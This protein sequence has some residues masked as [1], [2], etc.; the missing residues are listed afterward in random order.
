MTGLE[1]PPGSER[2]AGLAVEL[3]EALAARVNHVPRTHHLRPDG[4]P[5]FV[6]R[7]IREASPYLIQHAHNPV[8]WR[9][10][11]EE[12]LAEAAALDRPVFLSVGYATCHWCHV[13][14]EESFD[15]LEVAAVLNASFVPVKLDREQRPDVDQAYILA[16]M[17]QHRHAGWPNSVWL[18]PDGRP[19]HT[20]TYFPKP[21]FVQVLGAIAQGW[22]G[23]QRDQFEG[24][25]GQ[26]ADAMRRIPA[27]SAPPAELTE[28]P[29]RA[30]ADL[31]RLFNAEHGGFSQGTQFP[32]EG[33]LL[34]LM[35]H[36]RRTGDAAARDAALT[37]LI[38]MAA[39][40][41]HDHVGGGF[42][43]Y[44]VDV[45]WRTPHFE[46]MLYNQALLMRC[47]TEAWQI[48]GRPDFAR[49]VARC[50]DYVLRDMTAPDGAFYSAED[51]DSLDVTGKQ[52]EG[53]FYVW[54]PEE[55]EDDWLRD[56]LNLHAA[57][58]LEAG[59]V[60]HLTPG[61][62]VDFDRLDTGLEALRLRRDARPRPLRDD[63]VIGGWNGLMIRALAEAG[64]AFARPEWT[65]AAA[66][67]FDAVMTRLGPIEEMARLDLDGTRREA[68]NLSDLAWLGLAALS[69]G[70]IDEAAQMA[71]AALARFSTD[72]RLALTLDGP[73]GPVLETE[74]GAV[75]SG[76]SSALEL[77]ALL[78]AA[79][80]DPERRAKAEALV[81]AL[82]GRLAEMP[83]ARLEA[84]RASRILTDGAAGW[85]RRIGPVQLILR[86]TQDDFTLDLHIAEG[87]HLT[88]GAH[89]ADRRPLTLD[90]ADIDWP[91]PTSGPDGPVWQNTLTLP[92]RPAG[93][94]LT[95]SWQ[96]CADT[97]CLLPVTVE[98]RWP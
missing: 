77:L 65:E 98:F 39:G 67:A 64:A 12:A 41:L 4:S 3:D 9:P 2:S 70:R 59:P 50:A 17:L 28:A 13:M 58:T 15:D 34:F 83:V 82:S 32:Q 76:E 71:D 23:G 74:D 10:W 62:A 36:W 90:G 80:P 27:Q 78:D 88:A 86:R 72:G 91:E 53:A 87:W 20:G 81:T 55:V 49:A 84:L 33:N 8:D 38:H 25:A 19:F 92:L 89:R 7:L 30:V 85:H 47:Y 56:T 66:R 57:P 26:L 75:P 46:K 63:K 11:G 29:T 5:R 37:S 52:E 48:A 95:V 21:Q 31:V 79:A 96:P 6:N 93:D 45:N 40:G 22:Q 1:T 73:L 61:A 42:H 94:T 69:L 35:D 14:E 54:P 18:M 24:V 60:A 44:T 16:T 68:A 51:A 43:R 97:H